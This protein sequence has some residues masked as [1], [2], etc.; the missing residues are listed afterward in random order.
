MQL[1]W[2]KKVAEADGTVEQLGGPLAIVEP[3]RAENVRRLNREA[4]KT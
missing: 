2:I 3:G 4:H 1:V